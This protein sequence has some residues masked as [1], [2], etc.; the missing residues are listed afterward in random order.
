MSAREWAAGKLFL[1]AALL[2]S[3]VTV[4]ILGFMVA[5]ALPL[6]SDG[7]LALFVQPWNPRQGMYGIYPLIAATSVISVLSILMAF[8]VSLG[9]AG[10]ISLMA[11][12]PLRRTFRRLVEM[13]T[14]IPTVIY[15]FVG[16]FLLVPIVREFFQQGSGMCILSASLM[17]SV[18]IAP[19]MIIFFCDG[20]ARVPA[21]YG[22]AADALGA[23]R[24]QKLLYVMLPAART[25]IVTG[26]I[27]AFA[28]AV[29]DTLI[30]LMIAGNA[31]QVPQSLLDSARTLTAHIALVIAADYESPEF[32]SIFACGVVLYL[33]TT[34]VIVVVRRLVLQEGGPRA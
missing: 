8:P 29:G 17:L 28:R 23:D 30:A 3:G 2:S 20:F 16:I 33:F 13:M 5:M 9:C 4:L 31:A 27:L 1:S 10:F 15:G 7:G 14:S 6:L 22:E 11:P 34:V 21:S 18:L 19:T 12:R 26:V 25:G 32:R 24:A